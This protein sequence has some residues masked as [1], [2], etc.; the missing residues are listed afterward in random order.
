MPVSPLRPSALLI[1]LVLAAPLLSA[2]TAD[3]V[4]ELRRELLELKTAYEA[5]IAALEQRLAT[6]EA[7]GAQPP[8]AE[9]AAAPTPSSNYFNPSL[10]VIGNFLAVGGSNPDDNL[11]SAEFRESEIGFQAVVD[12]YARGDFFLAFGE[13]GVELEEGF[14]TFTALP[15]D[16]LAKVGRMRASFGKVNTLHLHTLPWPDLPLPLVNL[17]GSDEGWIGTG[18]SMARILPLP[19][20]TFS[21]LTLQVFRGEAEGLFAGEK[22][23]DLAWNGHYRLFRD[24]TEST[25]LDL[26]FSYAVG[27]NGTALGA[28]TRLQA[29]DMTLRWKPLETAL[30]RSAT[31]RGEY[32]RSRR[33]E[34]EGDLTGD[35]W[36]VS[37]DYQLARRWSVGARF[38]ASDHGDDP[39]ARDTGRA[40]LL[41]FMPT[42]FSQLRGELRRREYATGNTADEL[43]FQLQF[44]IGAHGGH[45]F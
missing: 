29:V 30:Y 33:E 2:Q 16:L 25:N 44:A 42:E 39:E 9:P 38:E 43:L 11:P 28:D 6:L 14:I 15:A 12:P 20:D 13:E 41:T 21:E 32:F 26:G 8:A 7:T 31:F 45:P 4:A 34:P 22:R 35:G 17:L 5:Q 36:F 23:S 1:L 27:P 19:G 3:P 40:L 37:G 24:L 10:A 18:V